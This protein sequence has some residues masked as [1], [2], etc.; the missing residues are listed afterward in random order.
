[1]VISEEYKALLSTKHATDPSWG[2]SGREFS[3][4]VLRLIQDYKPATVLD[5]GCG[6]QTLARSL[7]A[8]RICGYDPG[9]PGMDASPTPMD[10]VVCTDVL[11]HIE[12]DCIDDVL[13]DLQ[14]VTKKVLFATICVVPAYHKLPDGRNA[15]LIVKPLKWWLTRVMDRFK[16]I[17]LY[18]SGSTVQ[19]L[20]QALNPSGNGTK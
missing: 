19:I 12:P 4:T 10:L 9:I 8:Y 14:R 15:H 20:A 2:T 16:L 7:P 5:Y 18:D 17:S 6:K 11:E 1:M 13:D 3:R